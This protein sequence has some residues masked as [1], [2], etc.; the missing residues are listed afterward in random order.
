MERVHNSNRRIASR[1]A[2]VVR[3]EDPP[4]TRAAAGEIACTAT[5]DVHVAAGQAP[6]LKCEQQ[7]LPAPLGPAASLY[8]QVHAAIGPAHP[9]LRFGQMVAIRHRQNTKLIYIALYDLLRWGSRPK[10]EYRFPPEGEAQR[11]ELRHRRALRANA[12][13]SGDFTRPGSTCR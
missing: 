2:R 10:P 8:R 6:G 4:S 9:V 5:G 11:P 1:A 12:V 13:K 3:S 7:H